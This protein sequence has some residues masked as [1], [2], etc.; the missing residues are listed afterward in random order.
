MRLRKQE[1]VLR[2]VILALGLQIACGDSPAAPSPTGGVTVYQHP[3][4]GGQH[5]NFTESFH[6]LDDL[7]GPC[8]TLGPPDAPPGASWNHCVSSIKIA[9]GWEA[10]AFER[11]DYADQELRITSDIIDLDDEPGPCGGDWDDCI[12]SIRVFRAS[13]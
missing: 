4:Y 13:G 11:D 8:G 3:N 7:N 10:I 12:S 9:E 2:T 1:R 5:Y 6:N